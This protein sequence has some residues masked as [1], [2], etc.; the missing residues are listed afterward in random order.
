VKPTTVPQPSSRKA[1]RV[2]VL[3]DEP[4]I[5]RMFRTALNNYGYSTEMVGD[6]SAALDAL[7]RE[8]F[9]IVVSDVHMPDCG[10]LE[11]L[12]SVR[13]RFDRIPVILMTGRPS[14][15][16]SNEALELGVVRCLTKPVMP[17]TLREAIERATGRWDA[18]E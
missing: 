1:L 18:A 12:R 7:A 15:E 13:Q 4:G 17:Q 9:D 16:T 2:L 6:A 11:F 10:G 14:W 3:D 8:R 5:L